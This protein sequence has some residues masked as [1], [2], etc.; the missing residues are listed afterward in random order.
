MKYKTKWIIWIRVAGNIQKQGSVVLLGR[1]DHVLYR[2]K[3]L[4]LTRKRHKGPWSLD[5][6]LDYSCWRS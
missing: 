2:E 3:L 4:G 6:E 1:F 5:V